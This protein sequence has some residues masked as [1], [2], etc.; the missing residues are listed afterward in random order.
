MK[1][2]NFK[3]YLNELK[4][5]EKSY[6]ETK[7]NQSFIYIYQVTDLLYGELIGLVL[8]QK[9][10]HKS[11]YTLFRKNMDNVF[12]N[13][14]DY[15]T[16]VKKEKEKDIDDL[17]RLSLSN[18]YVDMKNL[19]NIYNNFTKELNQ[20]FE[21]EK[22]VQT[23]VESNT[24][25]FRG[26]LFNSTVILNKSLANKVIDS[27]K[28]LYVNE[29]VNN[30]VFKRNNVLAIYQNF[31]NNVIKDIYE[32][33]LKVKNQ[34]LGLISNVSYD[35][36]KKI[37]NENVDKYI[38]E[39]KKIINSFFTDFEKAV[40]DKKLAVFRKKKVNNCKDYFLNFNSELSI[41]IKNVFEEMNDIVSLDNEQIRSKLK[42]FNEL[43]THIFQI[44]LIFDKQFIE[45]KS[46]FII[47]SSEKFDNLYDKHKEKFVNS[48]KQNIF[49]I[50]RDN[51]KIYNDTVYKTML[52]KSKVD[53]YEEVLTVTKIKEL[54]LK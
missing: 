4:Q 40:R 25:I 54:L 16:K 47:K 20:S 50:F 33:K 1:R 32:A 37:E 30:L 14:K 10:L 51:I 44:N 49:N 11:V 27:Y 45:Y 24:D 6:S 39:N 5:E 23:L 8:D 12:N 18:N 52:L 9:A 34:N 3:D 15:A 36:L 17:L 7:D 42:D 35:Y 29:L 26:D 13:L 43:I 22:K 46:F 31:I 21:I 38:R 28:K 48:L 53:E 19:N 2:K 41:M